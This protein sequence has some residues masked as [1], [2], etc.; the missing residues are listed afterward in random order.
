MSKLALIKIANILIKVS[1]FAPELLT[2]SEKQIL[3]VLRDE[4]IVKK[5]QDSG[6]YSL[7]PIKPLVPP[8]IPA[9]HDEAHNP[10]RT[11][12]VPICGGVHDEND[13]SFGKIR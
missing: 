3:N 6:V 2:E 10:V 11:R 1:E 12:S 13:G 5:N 8:F 9:E 4:R 7:M